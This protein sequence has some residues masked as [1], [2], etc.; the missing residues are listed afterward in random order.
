L[1]NGIKKKGESYRNIN[2]FEMKYQGLCCFSLTPPQ[3]SISPRL[4][5]ATGYTNIKVTLTTSCWATAVLLH[6]AKQLLL[7]SSTP[8]STKPTPSER[9]PCEASAPAAHWSVPRCKAFYRTM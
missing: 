9:K 5:Q 8:A 6:S 4:T 3:L 2:S 7:R 1:A